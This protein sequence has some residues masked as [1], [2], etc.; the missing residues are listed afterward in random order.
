MIC[1]P[2]SSEVIDGVKKGHFEVK[3]LK[4][5]QMPMICIWFDSKFFF[6]SKGMNRMVIQGYQEGITDHSKVDHDDIRD[7]HTQYAY[8]TMDN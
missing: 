7:I 5:G 2:R 3:N 8:Q 4:H 6:D 1:I